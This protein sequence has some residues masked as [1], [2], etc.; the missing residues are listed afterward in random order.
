M[1]DFRI[2]QDIAALQRE[3]LTRLDAVEKALNQMRRGVNMLDGERLLDRWEACNF[4]NVS[5][6]QIDRMTTAQ[7]IEVVK[8]GRRTFFKISTLENYLKT[9]SLC[10]KENA[11]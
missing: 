10:Q 3:I 6:R 8:I 2:R 7:E 1:E 5:I 9:N 4:L 11:Y